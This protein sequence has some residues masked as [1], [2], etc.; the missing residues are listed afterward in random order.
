MMACSLRRTLCCFGGGYIYMMKEDVPLVA[1][2]DMR[3]DPELA[4]VE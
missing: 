2:D 1:S 3:L 4:V